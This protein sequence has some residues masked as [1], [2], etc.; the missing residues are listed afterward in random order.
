MQRLMGAGTWQLAKYARS[1]AAQKVANNCFQATAR[2]PSL[3]FDMITTV[4]GLLCRWA[5]TRWN[6]PDP[7]VQLSAYGKAAP[8]P[9]GARHCAR[10]ALCWSA[11][12][13]SFALRPSLHRFAADRSAFGTSQ[14]L[15]RPDFS[16][17]CIIGY[18]TS[19]CRCGPP[20]SAQRTARHEISGS[21]AIRL[22]VMWPSTP[23]E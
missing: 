16:C 17:P 19:S 6:G 8:V 5:L 20:A 10:C 2:S 22:R 11:F 14:L 15:W 23:P 9:R 7:Y 13:L 1:L 18:N 4:S 12:P 21:D 3:L